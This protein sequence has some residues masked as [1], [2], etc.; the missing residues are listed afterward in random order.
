MSHQSG[1][2][3]RSL[4]AVLLLSLVF[5]A[6]AA[7][8]QPRPDVP[9]RPAVL[10]AYDF[11]LAAV[12]LSSDD[13]RFTWD[14]HWGGDVDMIDYVAGRANVLVDYEAILGSELRAFDPNQGNYVLEASGS[15]RVK[16]TEVAGVFHHVSR[17]RSDRPKTFAIA[18]NVAGARMLRRLAFGGGQVDMRFEGG[19]VV[20]HAYVDY[21]WTGGGDVRFDR[22]VTP[23]VGVFGHVAGEAYGVRRESTRGTQTGGLIEGGIRLSGSGGA[24]ELYGGYEHRVDADQIDE[25]PLSWVYGGFRLVNR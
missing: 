6:P 23:A 11:H 24:L 1:S 21:N 2:L 20:Q 9:E 7:A 18:W 8:Q 13:N 16:G 4:S 17:H 3:I 14:T 25:E 5:V 10:T 12:G 19:K 22:A 15:A